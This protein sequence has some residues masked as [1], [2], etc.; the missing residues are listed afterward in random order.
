MRAIVAVLLLHLCVTP[1]LARKKPP[2]RVP[3]QAESSSPEF[4]LDK[5]LLDTLYRQSVDEARIDMN[6]IS[7]AL[8]IT[9][10][11]SF[12][13]PTKFVI[14]NSYFEVPYSENLHGVPFFHLILST[15]IAFWDRF[16]VFAQGQV[17]YTYKEGLYTNIRSRG[18]DAGQLSD[19][20][21]LSW[22]PLLASTRIEYD[23]PGTTLVKPSITLGAG[24]HWI[25]QSGKLDGIEQGF[26]I[27]FYSTGAALTLFD[28]SRKAGEWFGGVTVGA[29][30]Q[31]SFG[32]SQEVHAWSIDVGTHLVL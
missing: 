10:Q 20:I 25:L 4:R 15:P 13:N 12:V 27:P 5:G 8:E 30:V 2:S 16:V 18:S 29:T 14:S 24:M 19:V 26:W 3:S 28:Q 17:G 1:A 31:N 6:P 22:L 7:G 32:S 21:R 23:I 9:P 11:I